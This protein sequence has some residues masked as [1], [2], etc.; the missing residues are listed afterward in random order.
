MAT[1]TERGIASRVIVPPAGNEDEQQVHIDSEEIKVAVE[2]LKEAGASIR[3]FWD[4]F[5]KFLQS[6]LYLNFI[7]MGVYSYFLNDNKNNPND[8]HQIINGLLFQPRQG[9]LFAICTIGFVGAIASIIILS[10]LAYHGRTF[11]GAAANIE[12]FIHMN[13]RPIFPAIVQFYPR[14]KNDEEEA[15][16]GKFTMLIAGYVLI[17]LFVIAW[18]L[19][20]LRSFGINILF[21]VG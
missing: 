8:N 3:S 10:R 20:A 13:S 6:F 11:L 18:F 17:G 19:G 12:N 1:G 14:L 16:K 7:L 9:I 5:T 21:F 2:L 4:L 15:Q